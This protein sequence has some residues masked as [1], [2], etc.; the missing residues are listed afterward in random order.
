MTQEQYAVISDPS[1]YTDKG[2][3]WHEYFDDK[4]RMEILRI[5]DEHPDIITE[6]ERNPTGYREHPSPHLQRVHNYFRMQPTFGK[7]YIYTESAWKV[8]RIAEIQE[9]GELPQLLDGEYRTEEEAMHAVFL[10]RIEDIR[11]Q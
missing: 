7:Y 2:L 11:D 6:H 4:R 5:L 1:K 8:Y 3:H 9:F 10:K